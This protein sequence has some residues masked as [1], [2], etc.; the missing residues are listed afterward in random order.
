MC[1]GNCKKELS[2]YWCAQVAIV[3]DLDP[4]S[5]R[6]LINPPEDRLE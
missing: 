3:Q 4:A 1:Y 5:T 2:S 6:L